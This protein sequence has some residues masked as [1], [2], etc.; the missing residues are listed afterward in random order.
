MRTARPALPGTGGQPARLTAAVLVALVA[1]ALPAVGQEP[2]ST[3][4]RPERIIEALLIWRLVDELDLTEGQIARIFPRLRALKE[5]RLEMGRRIRP[6]VKDLRQLLAAQP[7]DEELIRARM[8][9]L[10]QL[11]AEMERRRR[12]QLQGIAEALSPHQQV[13]F[14]LIQDTFEVETLRLLDAAR[15]L[16]EEQSRR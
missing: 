3:P 14:I 9:E 6:L 15:R 4:P 2:R 5:I 16:A 12:E 7:R 11:R 1:L 13:R 10:N 8:A